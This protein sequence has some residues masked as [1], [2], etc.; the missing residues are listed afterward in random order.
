MYIRQR[1]CSKRKA[2]VAAWN[3]IPLTNWKC[4]GLTFASREESHIKETTL[5]SHII[6]QNHV[7]WYLVSVIIWASTERCQLL[8]EPRKKCYIT[9]RKKIPSISSLYW[10]SVTE[11]RVILCFMRW[12]CFMAQRTVLYCDYTCIISVVFN[13]YVNWIAILT[14]LLFNTHMSSSKRKKIV[15]W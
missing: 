9:H 11:K 3:H 1:C 7:D 10:F 12:C 15:L 8:R 13:L 2:S 4:E 6:C 5:K 14:L